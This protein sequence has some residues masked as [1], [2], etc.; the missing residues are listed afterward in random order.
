MLS[1]SSSSS[2]DRCSIITQASLSSLLHASTFTPFFNNQM[3]SNRT[4]CCSLPPAA[5]TYY[6]PGWAHAPHPRAAN[7]PWADS[8]RP[9]IRYQQHL[10]VH[11]SAIAGAMLP[12][13]SP[14]WAPLWAPLQGIGRINV[15][16]PPP[17]IEHLHDGTRC[18]SPFVIHVLPAPVM[19]LHRLTPEVSLSFFSSHHR[20]R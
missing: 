10:S 8:F 6:F 14:P 7:K 9:A 4:I 3:T 15:G 2:S 19:R 17:S 20:L 12:L 11:V 13:R 18:S 16:T 5:T 1:S